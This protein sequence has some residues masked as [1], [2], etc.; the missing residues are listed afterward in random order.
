M[1]NLYWGIH[2]QGVVTLYTT[3]DSSAIRIKIDG[4]FGYMNVHDY[5]H[6]CTSM[7]VC[8]W[9]LTRSRRTKKHLI[10]WLSLKT[11]RL[12]SFCSWSQTNQ[13][14]YRPI[15]YVIMSLFRCVSIATSASQIFAGVPVQPRVNAF[16]IVTAND[17]WL[18]QYVSIRWLVD[19]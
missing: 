15:V 5:K 12:I 8:A 7:H 10:S 6:V 14:L 2:P 16:C 19:S 11:L 17:W 1:H 3:I 9:I 13:Q 4:Y 18:T